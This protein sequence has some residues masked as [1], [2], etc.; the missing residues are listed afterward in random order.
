MQQ[1]FGITAEA[2]GAEVRSF[3]GDCLDQIGLL[4]EPLREDLFDC[5]ELRRPE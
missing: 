1:I 2:T 5:F 3:Q 4:I